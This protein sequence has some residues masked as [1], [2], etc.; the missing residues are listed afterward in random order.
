MN[1]IRT[2]K[3]ILIVAGEESGDQHASML[4]RELLS[5]DDSIRI[6]AFGARHLKAAG[7][8]IVRDM[9]KYAVNGVAE[10]LHMLPKFLELNKYLRNWVLNNNPELAIL[11]DFPGFNLHI[12]PFLANRMPVLYFIPPKV[13]VWR[14]KRAEL[15]RKY[16]DRVYTIFPF[17]NEF[18]PQK[19]RYFGNPLIDA[20]PESFERSKFLSQQGL[21]PAKTYVGLLP[22]SRRHEVMSMLP[23]Y[24]KTARE[25]A[26]L[27][28]EVGFLLPRVETL[29]MSCYQALRKFSVPGLH[30]LKGQSHAIMASSEFVLATSGTVTLESALLST[31]M[32]ICYKVGF[33]TGLVY[34]LLVKTKYVGLPNLLLQ[35]ELCPEFLQGAASPEK[36][37]S[38]CTDWLKNPALLDDQKEGFVEIRL[39]IGETGVFR[40]IAADLLEGFIR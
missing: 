8:N 6:H 22:G 34:K 2:K 39:K 24:L 11:V 26:Q 40:R 21:D 3:K 12:L 4:V 17:E 25:L 23:V 19:A 28:P 30:V 20:L 18:Y 31:P 37:L 7:A 16:C 15:L 38:V 1:Q 10:I 35:R 33:L 29:S 5:R 14:Q 27:F 13:W 9:S 32:L 36:L